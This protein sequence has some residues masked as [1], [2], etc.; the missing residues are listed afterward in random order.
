MDRIFAFQLK[1]FVSRVIGLLVYDLG[2]L[3]CGMLWVY[4]LKQSYTRGYLWITILG[5][6]NCRV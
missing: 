1:G 5:V 6:R 4:L 2:S 3:G